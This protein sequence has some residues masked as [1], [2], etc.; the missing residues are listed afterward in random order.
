V[1]LTNLGAFANL[2]DIRAIPAMGDSAMAMYWD[3]RTL[4]P[5]S[6]RELAYSYGQGI[7]SNPENE[8]KVE[9]A[10][11][12]SFEPG[13]L[14]NVTA[15]VEDPAPG[16]TLTLELPAGMERMEG[17][18]LQPVP[19]PAAEG[20]SIVMWKARV[21]RTGEYALRVRSSTGVTQTKVI[22]ISKAE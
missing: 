22:T 13:K 5:G 11:G 10:L 6:K 1:I 14:F 20:N 7:A 3:K 15:Y 21:C 19:A 9:V 18:E 16:Q 4:Q 17:K 2:W 12:G 8:G